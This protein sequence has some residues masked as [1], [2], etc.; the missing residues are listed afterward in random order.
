MLTS[1][2]TLRSAVR[3]VVDGVLVTVL[4]GGY[5]LLVRDGYLRAWFR[6]RSFAVDLAISSV[7]VVALFLVGR[8]I[9]Q[10]VTTLDPGRFAA[11]LTEPH[12]LFFALPYFVVLAVAMPRSA[13]PS[14]SIS[15]ARPRWRNGWGAPATSSCSAASWT[16]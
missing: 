10:V 14:S 9:G 16:T 1:A 6:R 7:T 2:P 8:G 4:V 13:S 5:L 3:G 15:R 11:S 12:L